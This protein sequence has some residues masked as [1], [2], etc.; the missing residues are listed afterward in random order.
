MQESLI[1]Q[2][3]NSW[4][5]CLYKK[6]YITVNQFSYCI[7]IYK[8]K[9]F[10]AEFNL[11]D[12]A[13]LNFTDLFRSDVL[14]KLPLNFSIKMTVV[15]N[16]VWRE[17]YRLTVQMWYSCTAGIIVCTVPRGNQMHVKIERIFQLRQERSQVI[18]YLNNYNN[19][20]RI[21]HT[22]WTRARTKIFYVIYFFSLIILKL[23]H[24]NFWIQTLIEFWI[25]CCD[26]TPIS[27]TDSGSGSETMLKNQLLLLPDIGWILSQLCHVILNLK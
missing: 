19:R 7:I 11:A 4:Y 21:L 2:R 15:V 24:S 13:L 3:I 14:C 20:I 23:H 27:Q 16:L 6:L 22:T 26:Q 8:Y 5:K 10:L 25:R 1:P 17:V 18:T 12:Q 9:W